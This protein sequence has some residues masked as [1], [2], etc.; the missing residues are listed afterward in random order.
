MMHIFLTR[1]AP[2]KAQSFPWHLH[3]FSMA[4]EV[5]LSPGE[6]TVF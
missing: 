4:E 2:M 3:G 6:F 1:Q 5:L